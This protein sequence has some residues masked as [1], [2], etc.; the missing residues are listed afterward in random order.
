MGEMM[1][2]LHAIAAMPYSESRAACRKWIHPHWGE[3]VPADGAKTMYRAKVIYTVRDT[4]EYR[5]SAFT[6]EEA[7]DAALEE[8]WKDKDIPSDAE[9]DETELIEVQEQ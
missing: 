3:D 5:I 1:P 6:E 9:H 4:V 7:R 2:S 8:F